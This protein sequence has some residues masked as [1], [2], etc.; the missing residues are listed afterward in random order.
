MVLEG[1]VV[2]ERLSTRLTHEGLERAMQWHVLLQRAHLAVA[3]TADLASIRFHTQVIK[4]VP[5]EI[6]PVPELLT[7]GLTDVGLLPGVNDLVLFQTGTALEALVAKVALPRLLVGMDPPVDVKCAGLREALP[8]R[9]ALVRPFARV[10]PLVRQQ[11][12]LQR[13]ALPTSAAKIRLHPLMD[14]FVR[15]QVNEALPARLA[16]LLFLFAVRQEVSFESFHKYVLLP[17]FLACVD[18]RA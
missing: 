14:A 15:L 1:V 12:V 4:H 3:L 17:T 9:L 18:G 13:E 11:N 7:T 2:H 8:A 6:R 16:R 5:S 10:E